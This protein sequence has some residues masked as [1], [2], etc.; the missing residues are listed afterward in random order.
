M[1]SIL[2]APAAAVLATAMAVSGA[3]IFI[4]LRREKHSQFSGSQDT[5]PAKQILRPCLSSVNS[6]ELLPCMTQFANNAGGK[7]GQKKKKRVQF[8]EGVKGN[9][10]EKPAVPAPGSRRSCR[11]EI[12]G[13]P[14]NRAA[15]YSGILRDRTQRMECSY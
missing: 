12:R 8:A 5:H 4:S 11:D 1:S 9:G 6:F 3:V 7:R 10:G 13:M 15:L 2:S 14:A